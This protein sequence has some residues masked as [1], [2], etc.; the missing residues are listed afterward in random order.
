MQEHLRVGL[1]EFRHVLQ[2]IDGN[3]V[4]EKEVIGMLI[5]LSKSEKIVMSNIPCSLRKLESMMQFYRGVV[6][7]KAS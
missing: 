4:S 7:L 6:Y 1:L 2:T 5:H 3:Q